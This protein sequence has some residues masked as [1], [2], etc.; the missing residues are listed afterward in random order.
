MQ[1]Q[2]SHIPPSSLLEVLSE[3]SELLSHYY[4]PTEMNRT[5]PL[6]SMGLENV[7]V[8]CSRARSTEEGAFPFAR[9]GMGE[10]V[11]LISLKCE[12]SPI[13]YPLKKTFISYSSLR[14]DK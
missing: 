11:F 2:S 4:G 3:F 14:E 5:W 12:R 8:V 13:L 7:K 1:L 9:Y 10:E 6:T